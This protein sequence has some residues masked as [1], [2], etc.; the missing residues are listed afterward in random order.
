[1]NLSEFKSWFEGYT[2]NLTTTPNAKQWKRI[3]TRVAEITESPTEI[4]Y[5][6]DHYWRPY[7]HRYP[8]FC[9][10]VGQNVGHTY[11][12]PATNQSE[13]DSNS[14]IPM[15]ANSIQAFAALG[16]AESMETT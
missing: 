10:G 7:Y 11:T 15:F 4:R 16:R 8:S 9:G 12:L 5:F 3:Q 13:S 2:E 14:S 1:M 6:Y